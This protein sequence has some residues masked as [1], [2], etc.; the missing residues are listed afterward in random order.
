MLPVITLDMLLFAALIF[1]LRVLNYS[2]STVRTV[3]I[4][5][6]QIWLSSLLAFVEAFLFAVVIANVVR[7]LNNIINLLAYCLGA[8]AGGYAGMALESR[9]ITS[10]RVLNIIAHERG[11]ELAWTL[12]DQGYGVTLIE[13]QGRDGIVN[14]LRCVVVNR[15]V[16]NVKRITNEI[17]P[18]AFIAVEEARAIE[19][20]WMHSPSISRRQGG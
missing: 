14:M 5:R 20:G 4:A 19:R 17:E 18:E 12:R 7:D 6:Q 10:Y 9:F 2:V 11:Q 13:G 3:A 16:P 1:V 15:D 8:A